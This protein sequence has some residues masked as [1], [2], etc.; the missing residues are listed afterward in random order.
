MWFP[1]PRSREDLL[2]PAGMGPEAGD[3][4]WEI[5]L[6]PGLREWRDR[7]GKAGPSNASAKNSL[8]LAEYGGWVVKTD[9]AHPF[10][11][12]DQLRRQTDRTVAL[13]RNLSLWHP[14]KHWLLLRQDTLDGESA[15]EY[16]L[17]LTLCPCL[18]TL[19][20][21]DDLAGRMRA[22]SRMVADSVKLSVRYATGVDVNPSNFGI[23]NWPAERIRSDLAPPPIGSD[24]DEIYYVD[25]EVQA[26]LSAVSLATAVASRVP[27]E[28]GAAEDQWRQ[29]G[30]SIQQPLSEFAPDPH[31]LRE[32]VALISDYPVTPRFQK[33]LD[34]LAEGIRAGHPALDRASRRRRAAPRNT[35]VLADVHGNLP[36]LNAVLAE[37]RALGAD[38]FLFLGDAVGYGPQPRE[39]IDRLSELPA[40]IL[41]RGN[42]D[43]AVGTGNFSENMNRVARESAAWT[44][45]ELDTAHRRWLASL[46]LE[47]R[48]GSAWLAVH[49]APQDPH[50]IFAYVYELTFRENLEFLEEAGLPLCFHGHSH[51]QGA[52]RRDSDGAMARVPASASLDL[53]EA[54]VRLLVNPGSTGQPR[55][56]EPTAAFA[57]WDRRAGRVGFIR[58]PYA[59]E[60]VA[61]RIRAAGLPLDLARRLEIGR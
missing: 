25:E 12:L 6:A 1:K 42:H 19:R 2:A 36:A 11:D 21:I 60:T 3:L 49:G 13:S 7:T 20:E 29:F 54:G 61:S 26:P 5:L 30:S 57:M 23:D 16:W 50:R 35:C 15:P 37:A 59:L 33:R 55:D 14:G 8:R 18:I 24:R 47:Y 27:E 53:T 48:E 31:R 38:S 40:A 28:A 9:L 39:C 51:I 22:W 58:V 4:A 10:S 32:L 46:P 41:L 34:A 17:S 52:F 56:G 45:A 43:H 44:Y